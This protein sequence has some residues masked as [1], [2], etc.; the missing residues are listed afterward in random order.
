MWTGGLAA[1]SIAGRVKSAAKK[2][3]QRKKAATKPQPADDDGPADEPATPSLMDR[4]ADEIAATDHQNA[5]SQIARQIE[6]NVEV[7]SLDADQAAALF[8]LLDAKRV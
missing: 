6:E 3:G 2:A 8:K 5:L 1:L 7:G 4:F